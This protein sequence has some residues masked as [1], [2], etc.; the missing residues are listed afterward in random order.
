MEPFN[1]SSFVMFSVFKVAV[2]VLPEILLYPLLVTLHASTELTLTCE[3][4]TIKD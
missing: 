1:F 4:H 3:H 2:S